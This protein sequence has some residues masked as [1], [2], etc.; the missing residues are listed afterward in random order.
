MRRLLG[1]LLLAGLAALTALLWVLG[2]SRGIDPDWI[3]NGVCSGNALGLCQVG[4][5][6]LTPCALLLGWY[7]PGWIRRGAVLVLVLLLA[8]QWR[9]AALDAD[10]AA[11]CGPEW[12]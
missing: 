2:L 9:A 3:D 1:G 6:V 5:R 12:R 11:A 8:G 7:W 4:L 10:R